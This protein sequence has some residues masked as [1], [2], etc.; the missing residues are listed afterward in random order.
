MDA[1]AK[2]P[3]ISIGSAEARA[4][5]IGT[6]PATESSRKARIGPSGS[7]RAST[8]RA[9][10]PSTST[11]AGTHAARIGNVRTTSMGPRDGPL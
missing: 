9:R 3:E 10:S 1:A 2:P 8:I 7:G 4:H 5:G 11:S 6:R